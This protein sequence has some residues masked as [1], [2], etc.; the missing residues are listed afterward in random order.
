[1][2]KK[3]QKMWGKK[4][5]LHAGDAIILGNWCNWSLSLSFYFLVHTQFL[6]PIRYRQFKY[7]KTLDSH[8]ALISL[9][10]L[11]FYSSVS[12]LAS[13]CI[14][15]M[16]FLGNWVKCAY[17]QHQLKSKRN[18]V[19]PLSFCLTNFFYQMYFIPLICMICVS[20]SSTLKYAI[21]FN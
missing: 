10:S 18:I 17:M 1:M 7:I 16:K 11:C 14:M 12:F 20:S 2:W 13:F 15:M 6:L 21:F 9:F 3:R 4:L 5:W 8:S 19:F